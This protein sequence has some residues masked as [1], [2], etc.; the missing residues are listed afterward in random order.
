LSRYQVVPADLDG[1]A[2]IR[3]FANERIGPD[4]VALDPDYFRWQ[5]VD[6]IHAGRAGDENESLAVLADGKVVAIAN[7]RRMNIWLAGRVAEGVWL[8][9][10]FADPAF[11]GAGLL[12][13]RKIFQNKMF[14]GVTGHSLFSMNTWAR[15][16]PTCWFELMRVFA[17]ID[18]AATRDLLFQAG[19]QCLNFLHLARVAPKV[20]P[21]EEVLEFD[22][23]Y[24]ATWQNARARHL[25]ATDRSR[26][27]MNWRY[28]RHPVFKYRALRCEEG[29]DPVYFVWR[30]EPV[31]GSDRCVARMTEAIGEPRAICGALPIL[32]QG[33][34]ERGNVAFVDFFCSSADIVSAFL[35]AGFQHVITTSEFDLP[36]LFSPLA[37]DPRKSI[38]I[39]ISI[40]AGW[41]NP[42]SRFAH[43][44]TYITKGDCNQDRPNL[45]WRRS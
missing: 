13:I 31:L 25:V 40:A 22:D 27:F 21:A 24:E 18:P 19:P 12:P 39:A 34:H 8:H 28:I 17:A 11:A 23:D 4:Y 32:L 10:W 35:A 3:A 30:E 33:L 44:Q 6:P 38:N 45:S 16:K 9:E 37:N 41:I 42:H 43:H 7:A 26:A 2:S 1:L 5:F 20:G 15:L 14:M 29:G 36:R